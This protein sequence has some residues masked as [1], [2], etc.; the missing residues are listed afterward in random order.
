MTWFPLALLSAFSW[1]TADYL[2]KRWLSPYGAWEAA[3]FRHLYCVPFLWLLFPLSP[4]FHPAPGF[5]GT[6]GVLLPVEVVAT[7]LYMAA[8]RSSP[9]SLTLPFL[10]FTPLFLVLTGLWVLGERP[11][12]WGL[13]G[14]GLV[15]GGGYLLNL[16]G[17]PLGPLRAMRRERGSWMML[18]VAGLYAWTSAMGKR[19]LL[20]SHPFFF[21][22]LYVTLL[23]LCLGFG[24]GW[25]GLRRPPL[26]QGLAIGGM[27]AL[28]FTSHW[29]AIT[30]VDA[31]YMIAVKRTSP[32]FGVLYGGLALGEGEFGKRL[33]ATALMVVGVVLIAL[34]G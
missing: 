10:S 13:V 8:I 16:G 5:W 17:G 3:F 14:I 21:G 24:V 1:A 6:V 7:V 26:G 33:L 12:P 20:L 34:L 22:P 25:K 18:I 27:M 9:L 28:M 29:I 19:A 31:S 2:T 23:T 30:L 32:L 4:T 15:V 11:G